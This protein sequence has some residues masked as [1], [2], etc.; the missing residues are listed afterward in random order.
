MNPGLMEA[1]SLPTCV[2]SGYALDSIGWMAESLPLPAQACWLKEE[3]QT[4]TN[5]G[6]YLAGMLY[7]ACTFS[8]QDAAAGVTFSSPEEDLV[9]F[10]V[11]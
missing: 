6:L 5:P 7:R 4:G 9:E 1:A 3:S 8:F 10:E 11:I 2:I